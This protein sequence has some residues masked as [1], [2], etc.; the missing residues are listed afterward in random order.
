M[1]IYV[2][3]EKE[4]KELMEASRKIHDSGLDSS[5][6]MINTLMH[7]HVSNNPNLVSIHPQY[8]RC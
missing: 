4:W 1:R 8:G 3:S 6:E 7:L 2:E 5:N